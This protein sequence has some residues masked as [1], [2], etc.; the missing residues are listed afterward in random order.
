MLGLRLIY[1]SFDL[2]PENQFILKQKEYD[3]MKSLKSPN[4]FKVSEPK[5]S[6]IITS[7]LL[8]RKMG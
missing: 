8:V 6:L 7:S 3:D 2:E 4:K 1:V 5:D